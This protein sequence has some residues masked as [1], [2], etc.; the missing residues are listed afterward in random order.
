M[1][2]LIQTLNVLCAMFSVC[3]EYSTRKVCQAGQ[4]GFSFWVKCTA[5]KHRPELP[6]CVF[7]K[8][9]K[10]WLIRPINFLPC[11]IKCTRNV[12]VDLDVAFVLH[13][14]QN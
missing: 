12:T 8:D 7:G 10:A 4:V 6:F 2:S 1:K 13:L 11:S 5:F 9:M 3:I 14:I